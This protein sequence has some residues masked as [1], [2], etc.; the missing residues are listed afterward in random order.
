MSRRAIPVFFVGVLLL[1]SGCTVTGEKLTDRVEQRMLKL[2]GYYAELE[3]VVYSV[4]GERAYRVR[5]WLEMPDRWRVEV[6]SADGSQ[7]FICDGAHI[8][9]YQPGIEDYYRLD[10]SMGRQ[11]VSPPFMLAGYLSKMGKAATVTFGGQQTVEGKKTYLVTLPGA[12]ND[13]LVRIWL[14]AKSLFPA[15]VETEVDGDLVSR[16]TTRALKLNPKFAEG[17]FTFEAQTEREAAYHCLIRPLSLEEAKKDW[18][19]PVFTPSYLPQG[20]RLF[21]ISRGTEDGRERLILIYE[22]DHP[23]TLVQKEKSGQPADRVQGTQ[24]VRIGRYAG[25]YRKNSVNDLIT[26]WWANDTCDFILTGAIP[27]GELV[28]IASSLTAE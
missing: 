3:A 24:E 6:D 8:W 14:D 4:E 10:V 19:L 25:R 7:V 27:L 11:E 5:Q 18:P 13:D 1:L 28:K 9:V 22:G 16:V 26:V 15:V 20:S 17:L 2:H 12:Y 21:V 23:F